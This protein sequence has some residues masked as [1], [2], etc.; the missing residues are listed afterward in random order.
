M[1]GPV[2]L[3]LAAVQL[4][5]L[6]RSFNPLL[7]VGNAA[8]KFGN[9]RAHSDDTLTPYTMGSASGHH[10]LVPSTL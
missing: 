1:T 8:C 7:L 6:P 2:H 9:S 10:Q 4:E 3:L 5:V